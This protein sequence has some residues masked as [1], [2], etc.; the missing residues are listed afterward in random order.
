MNIYFKINKWIKHLKKNKVETESHFEPL[1]GTKIIS[2]CLRGI[3]ECG[4]GL[5]GMTLVFR[6]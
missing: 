5:G 2:K 1:L 6:N 4:S 3:W